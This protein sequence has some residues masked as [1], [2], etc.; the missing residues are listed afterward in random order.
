[1]IRL[2]TSG[3]GGGGGGGG[4]FGSGHLLLLELGVGGFDDTLGRG[5][6][7][8]CGLEGSLGTEEKLLHGIVRLWGGSLG[9]GSEVGG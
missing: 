1:M 4:C 2:L 8:D 6:Q 3:G 5:L 9:A 7:A